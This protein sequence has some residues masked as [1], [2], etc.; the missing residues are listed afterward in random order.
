MSATPDPPEELDWS[1]LN[2]GG[3]AF[4]THALR[5][6]TP[7]RCELCLLPELARV[8]R[9]F[10]FAAPVFGLLVMIFQASGE[11]LWTLLEGLVTTAL[12]LGVALWLRRRLANARVFDRKRGLYW[13]TREGGSLE[14]APDSSIPLSEIRGLQ[15]LSELVRG[16]SKFVAEE[17]NLVLAD[18]RRVNLVDYEGA[19]ELRA[20]ARALAQWLEVPLWIEAD[21]LTARAP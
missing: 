11:L 15:L 5:Q 18:G 13:D 16:E 7:E 3:W 1:P 14:Q 12:V 9:M 21:S 17:L 2:P 10:T 20:D 19:A 4:R 6:P 8:I